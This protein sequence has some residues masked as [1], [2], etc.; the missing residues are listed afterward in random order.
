MLAV[1]KALITIGLL[2]PPARA[3]YDDIECDKTSLLQVRS[4]VFRSGY[5]RSTT[6]SANATAAGDSNSTNSTVHEGTV[7]ICAPPHDDEDKAA[8]VYGSVNSTD[9]VKMVPEGDEVVAAGPPQTI[10]GHVMLPIQPSGAVKFHFFVVKEVKHSDA[11]G[12]GG[13]GTMNVTANNTLNVT[14]NNDT[15]A[16][17]SRELAFSNALREGDVLDKEK[18][19][20]YQLAVEVPPILNDAATLAA[21]KAAVDARGAAIVAV[22]LQEQNKDVWKKQNLKNKKE[23]EQDKIKEAKAE[24]QAAAIRA[25][26]NSTD[27]SVI[28]TPPPDEGVSHDTHGWVNGKDQTYHDEPQGAFH[29]PP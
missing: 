21:K 20:E 1:A 17:S 22:A 27:N 29:H 10:D 6:N 16:N 13:N 18:E 25:N 5:E 8:K 9:V 12:E 28:V 19:L 23:L 14:V 2:Y 3:K 24:Q 15:Y 11:I 26:G 4:A 7:F